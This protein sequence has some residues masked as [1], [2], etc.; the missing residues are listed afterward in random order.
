MRTNDL[1]LDGDRQSTAEG[2]LRYNIS[3]IERERERERVDVSPLI[4]WLGGVSSRA[5][6]WTIK[7]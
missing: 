1:L 6:K 7:P 4:L 3:A 2:F 5:A